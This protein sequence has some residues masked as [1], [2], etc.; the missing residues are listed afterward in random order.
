MCI[1]Y[2]MKMGTISPKVGIEPTS[3]AF[4]YSV[5]TITLPRLPDVTTLPTPIYLRGSLPERSVQTTIY[6]CI[7]IYTRPNTTVNVAM[8][9]NSIKQS[10]RYRYTYS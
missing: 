8:K 3:L 10:N 7:Y 9:K 4:R 5:L 2:V 6:T 1:C